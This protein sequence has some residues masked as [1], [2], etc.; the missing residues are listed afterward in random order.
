MKKVKF[1]DC[2]ASPN[3]KDLTTLMNRFPG[4]TD[5]K[6][7]L[8]EATPWEEAVHPSMIQQFFAHMFQTLTKF[9]FT[10][11]INDGVLWLLQNY[12][13][14]ITQLP[15]KQ[16]DHKFTLEVRLHYR[17]T[18]EQESD[19]GYCLVIDTKNNATKIIVQFYRDDDFDY[20]LQA[21][22]RA[23]EEAVSI[24]NAVVQ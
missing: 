23:L 9:K 3:N 18:Y 11:V 7:H 5:L 2:H 12:Y 15:T 21:A 13:E 22:S 16:E 19:G 6:L 10:V 8:V 20:D 24:P 1:N 14:S 4:L 17:Y